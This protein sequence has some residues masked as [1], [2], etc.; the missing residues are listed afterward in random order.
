[1]FLLLLSFSMLNILLFLPAGL[2]QKMEMLILHVASPTTENVTKN[3]Y[4]ALDMTVFLN[5]HFT[6]YLNSPV[7][8]FSDPPASLNV[9]ESVAQRKRR[10]LVA[11][12]HEPVPGS[13]RGLRALW[14]FSGNA[15]RPGHQRRRHRD[16]RWHRLAG[17]HQ[18]RQ[19]AGVGRS[20]RGWI[21][22]KCFSIFRKKGTVQ[23]ESVPNTRNLIYLMRISCDFMN[24]RAEECENKPTN[25]FL[26]LPLDPDDTPVATARRL[27]GDSEEERDSSGR[28]WRTVIIGDQ[29]Q[30][31]DM[32]VIRPYLRV[33]THGG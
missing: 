31:I 12:R 21:I 1:M 17:V 30:R 32:Q 27:P 23:V 3:K 14:R 28:L 29:E 8:L 19:R 4:T 33:V 16:P 5:Y 13:E 2:Y 9:G 6:L 11:P 25:N 26:V 20:D 18:Q 10:T 22:L 24:V 7:L 15:R